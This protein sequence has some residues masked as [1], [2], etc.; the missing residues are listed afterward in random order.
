MNMEGRSPRGMDDGRA[1][2]LAEDVEL[3]RVLS[4]A[5]ETAI[6]SEWPAEK[7]GDILTQ[8]AET[9]RDRHAVYGDNYKLVG[10]VMKALF[11]GGVM[12]KTPT[13]HNRFHILL[14]E[15]V[16]LTR[17]VQNWSRGGH[18]DS[19]LD[20]SVYAAMMVEI[21]RAARKEDGK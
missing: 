3:Q 4:D 17:Y 20:L 8:A 11:P 10:E 16:K 2:E 9:Y 12:L 1:N 13:D 5:V 14:L 6:A 7:A 18:D 19:Q 15:V 21:D